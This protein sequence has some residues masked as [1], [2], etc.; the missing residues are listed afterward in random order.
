M[1]VRSIGLLS[2]VVVSVAFATGCSKLE[3]ANNGK[4]YAG[5]ADTAAYSSGGGQYSSGDYKAGDKTG[6]SEALKVRSKGQNEY[7]RTPARDN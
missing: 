4:G 2:A 5:K 3:E 1:T 7:N 6:W